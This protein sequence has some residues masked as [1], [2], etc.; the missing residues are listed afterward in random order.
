MDFVVLVS[1]RERDAKS[2]ISKFA[3]VIMTRE[4]SNCFS[5]RNDGDDVI[6]M[7]SG[8]IIDS[9]T[10][11]NFLFEAA[12]RA[13]DWLHH[14]NDGLSAS[15]ARVSLKSRKKAFRQNQQR[16]RSVYTIEPGE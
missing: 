6:V 7:M 1:R 10:R 2:R 11:Q 3:G 16:A 8:P 9:V 15:R 5:A 12:S 14:G 4:R 13:Y